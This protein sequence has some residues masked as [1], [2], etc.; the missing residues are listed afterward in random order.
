MTKRDKPLSRLLAKPSDFE[1]DELNAIMTAFG[2]E[3]KKAGGSGRKFIHPETQ[4]TLFM[5]EPHPA[6]VLKAYQVKEVIRFLG[7]EHKIR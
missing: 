7:Q 1:W 3:L 5:H 6:K 2:Y 4:A